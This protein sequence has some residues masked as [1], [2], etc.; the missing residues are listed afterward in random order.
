M[1]AFH[2]QAGEAQILLSAKDK[3]FREGWA[4]SLDAILLALTPASS[5]GQGKVSP[6]QKI[7]HQNE[8]GGYHLGGGL[9]LSLNVASLAF[10]PSSCRCMLWCKTGVHSPRA[11][12]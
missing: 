5:S 10:F 4:T 9:I 7:Q 11:K 12:K 2:L 3:M 8:Y 6:T 1:E